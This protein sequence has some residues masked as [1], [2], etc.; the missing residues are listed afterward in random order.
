M[1]YG[2]FDD[3]TP[4]DEFSRTVTHEFGHALGCV[5]EQ[6]NPNLHITWNKQA[7][8]DYFKQPQNGGWDTATVDNNFNNFVQVSGPD[9]KA[10]A[11]DK[12][13]IMLYAIQSSWNQEGI[14]TVQKTVLSALDKTFIAAMYPPK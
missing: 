13:C 8:Y 9:F 7:V 5:H 14:S 12:D 1:N 6:F 4:D 11:F 2:W 10:T 3:S